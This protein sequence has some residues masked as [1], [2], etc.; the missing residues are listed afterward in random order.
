[1]SQLLFLV[2][3]AYSQYVKFQ[4]IFSEVNWGNLFNRFSL[5]FFPSSNF[6]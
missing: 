2:V 1:M 4:G 5:S 3:E 6:T